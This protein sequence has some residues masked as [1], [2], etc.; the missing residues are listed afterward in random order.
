[1]TFYFDTIVTNAGFPLNIDRRWYLLS[2][3]MPVNS[4]LLRGR[5]AVNKL[6]QPAE[7]RPPP[8]SGEF[9]SC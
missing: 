4:T 7:A 9:G 6:I 3:P 8:L 2:L 5:I 1:M